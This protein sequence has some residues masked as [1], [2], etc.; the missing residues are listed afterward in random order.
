MTP[1]LRI[2]LLL[3]IA[4]VAPNCAWSQLAVSENF[5]DGSVSNSWSPFLGACLTAGTG[6]GSVPACVGNSYYTGQTQVGGY[7]GTLPDPVG[8]G[9][10]RF[11]NGYP[12]YNQAGAII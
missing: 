7:S 4:A 3:A 6:T 11:T 12:N 2:T 8:N 5:T 9:A 1:K 10:L